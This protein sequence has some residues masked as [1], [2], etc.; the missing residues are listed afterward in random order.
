MAVSGLKSY[1]RPIC[2][3]WN[4]RLTAVRP[5]VEQAIKILL[6]VLPGDAQVNAHR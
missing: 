3:A 4:P 1:A 2:V 6:R 5:L